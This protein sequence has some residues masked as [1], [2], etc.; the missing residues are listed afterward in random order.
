M[1]NGTPRTGRTMQ[2]SEKRTWLA[3]SGM[4]GGLDGGTLDRVAD[5]ARVVDFDDGTTLFHQGDEANGL[6]CVA[7]GL[8]RIYLAHD[9]GRELTLNLLEKGDVIGEIALLDG[10]PRSAGATTLAQTRTVF[11]GRAAFQRLLE[12]CPQLA[13]HVILVLC[14]RLRRNTDQITQ[15]AFLDLRHRLTNLLWELAMGHGALSGT[16]GT[17]ELKLTQTSVAQM[18]GVTREAVNKQFRALMRDGILSMDKG[19]IIV[20][21]QGLRPPGGG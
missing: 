5:A 20:T 6:Y 10:L 21:R 8:V 14:E 1:V 2:T 3:G 13:Q 4:F 7:A 18:L 9:D 12:D 17:I 16:S 19:R 15:N 11:L